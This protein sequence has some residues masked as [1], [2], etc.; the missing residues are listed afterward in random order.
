MSGGI[1]FEKEKTKNDGIS[2]WV[3]PSFY[4]QAVFRKGIEI[5]LSC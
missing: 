3:E 5:E 2:G 4:L 1:L